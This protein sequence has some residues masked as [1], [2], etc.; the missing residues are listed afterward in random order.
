[1]KNRNY[2]SINHPHIYVEKKSITLIK[3]LLIGIISLG[4]V[5]LYAQ[6]GNLV[7]NHSFET[8]SGKVNSPGAILLA[9]SISSSNNTTVDIFTKDAC[10]KNYGVPENYMGSQQSKDGNNYAG[11]IAYYGD[12]TGFF[13]VMPGYQKNSW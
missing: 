6:K 5:A 10:S 8:L 7:L 1:M 9:D 4:T 12:E 13:N 2:V 3:A 11:F